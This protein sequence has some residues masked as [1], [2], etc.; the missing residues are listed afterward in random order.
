M[1][2][3]A[4]PPE[5]TRAVT[6]SVR[7]QIAR[8]LIRIGEQ[9]LSIEVGPDGRLRLLVAGFHDVYGVGPDPETW[10]YRTSLYGP[11]GTVTRY[12]VPAAGVLHFRYL[13]D[14]LSV[15]GCGVSPLQAAAL[16]GR[17]SAEVATAS[18]R[19][20]ERPAGFGDSDPVRG[21]TP[22]RRRALP[23]RS[24]T[25]GVRIALLT[26]SMNA[27]G[28]VVSTRRRRKTGNPSRLGHF[29]SAGF[30]RGVA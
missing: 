30:G 23:R 25:Y 4:G 1:A 2:T 19:R 21:P 8:S 17:L 20:I 28:V 15:L 6:A 16:A 9:V 13:T 7:A 5:L 24:A 18:C 29:D 14:P 12:D 11:S 22:I 27:A 10:T 3:V 26:E